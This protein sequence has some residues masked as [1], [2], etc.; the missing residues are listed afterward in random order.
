[1]TPT[2]QTRWCRKQGVADNA[3]RLAP[4]TISC[5]GSDFVTEVRSLNKITKTSPQSKTIHQKFF[6]SVFIKML[7][8][9]IYKPFYKS[10][11]V[12]FTNT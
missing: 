11:T 5:S 10:K 12:S 2:T 4:D 3:E 8:N 1:M 7:R 9:K 6:S